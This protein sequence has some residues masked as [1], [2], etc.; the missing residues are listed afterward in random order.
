MIPDCTKMI[1]HDFRK[2]SFTEKIV[3]WNCLL[4]CVVK[5]PPVD[6]LRKIQTGFGQRRSHEF[7]LGGGINVN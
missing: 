2:Y 3:L 6:S 5:S 7:D 4:T 1:K